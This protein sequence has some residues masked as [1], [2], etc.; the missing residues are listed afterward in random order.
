VHIGPNTAALAY[1]NTYPLPN[2]VNAGDGLNYQGFNFA[3]PLSETKNEYIARVDYNITSDAR[4]RISV[5]GALRNDA[6]PGAPFLPGQPPSFSN[7]NYNKGIIVSYAGVLK[8]SLINNFHYG[9]IRESVGTLG[10]S[11]QSWV[12]FRGLNDQTGAIT[13]SRSFQRPVNEFTDDLSRIHGKHTLQFGTQIAFIRNP[14]KSLN[15][16]FSF[17]SANPGW[18]NTTRFA[19]KSQ[20]PLNPS[21]NI[22]PATGQPF[23]QVDSG[24]FNSFDFPT[25]AVLGLVSEINAVYNFQRDGNPAPQGEPLVRH[26]AINSYEFYMQDVWKVKPTLTVTLGLR[27]SLFSPPWETKGLQVSPT[28]DL[29]KWFGNRVNEGENGIASNQDQPIAFDWSGPANGKASFYN[30]D[31]KNLGPRLAFAWAPDRS[32]GLLGGLFGAH[33]TVVRGGF[34]IVYDRFGQGLVDDFDQAGSF[35]LSTSLINTAE[36][37]TVSTSPRLADINTVPTTDMNGNTVFL[38]APAAKF[39]VPFPPG[40]FKATTSFDSGLKTPYS[41]TLDFSV[42]RELPSGFSM[43]VS[44]VG[45]LSHRL[46]A[47]SDLAMPL[48]FKDKKSGLDYFTAVTALAKIYRTGESTN[49]F[50]PSQLTPQVAQYWADVP[51]PLQAGG[52][53]Q[54]SN[55]TNNAVAAG[56]TSPVIAAYDWFCGGSLN[57]TTPLQFL[58]QGGIPNFNNPNRSYFAIGGPPCVILCR[59]SIDIASD[60]ERVGT[61]FGA[62]GGN[63]GTGAFVTN[64]WSPND[65]RSVSDF[66]ATHQFNA[67][68][69]L[70]MPFGR[71]AGRKSERCECSR[72]GRCPWAHRGRRDAQA[73]G[74]ISQRAGSFSALKKIQRHRIHGRGNRVVRR[75]TAGAGN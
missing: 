20:S 75:F 46:L 24:F 6:N 13:R 45:R 50:S 28:F 61:I 69:L 3:S 63:G 39:L 2:T 7:V 43:E 16:V 71:R 23:S 58:D 53:Y 12:L 26:F 8:P 59:R 11:A 22:N 65:F 72:N 21:N 25:T 67:N 66:D 57:E 15:G 10:N 17:A 29:G 55:G 47:Q 35:G 9:F 73:R 44:Y 37:L 49:S 31:F 64:S 32:S 27:Y 62:S 19:G 33:K 40:T 5:S 42:G 48:N 74:R 38:P 54:I 51:Q 34:G 70:E 52:L 30:W 1:L 14:R 36:A 60:A 41:Y 4:H 18:L 56:T 68:W